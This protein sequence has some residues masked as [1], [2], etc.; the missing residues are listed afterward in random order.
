MTSMMNFPIPIYLPANLRHRYSRKPCN[1][2]TQVLKVDREYNFLTELM[3]TELRYN[4][5][6]LTSLWNDKAASYLYVLWRQQENTWYHCNP[7]TEHRTI[8]LVCCLANFLQPCAIIRINAH[9]HNRKQN[10]R[11]VVLLM[12]PFWAHIV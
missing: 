1:I 11:T 12:Q 7:H 3:V 8:L 5:L 4:Y 10:S 2:F 9:L 6:S